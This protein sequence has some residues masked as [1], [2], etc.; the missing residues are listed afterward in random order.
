MGTVPNRRE[1]LPSAAMNLASSRSTPLRSNSRQPFA[2]AEATT[3][4]PRMM[5]LRAT[6]WPTR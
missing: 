2:N 6:N 5:L 1:S 3:G 4:S